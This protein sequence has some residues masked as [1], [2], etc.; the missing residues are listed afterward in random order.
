MYIS[1]DGRF[2]QDSG[3]FIFDI[4][5]L[6]HPRLIDSYNRDGYLAGSIFDGSIHYATHGT[7]TVIVDLAQPAG[8][9]VL[10][11]STNLFTGRTEKAGNLFFVAKTGELAIV[12]AVGGTNLQQVG[13][14]K[15]SSFLYPNDLAVQGNL[16]FLSDSEELFIINV[17]DPAAPK[18]L[19]KHDLP[20]TVINGGIHRSAGIIGVYSDH[21]YLHAAVVGPRELIVWDVSDPLQPKEVQRL[22]WLSLTPGP[23]RFVDDRLYLLTDGWSKSDYKSTVMVT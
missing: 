7:N 21:L 18:L 19:A 9:N 16:V 13:V 22:E 12:D 5:D 1:A 4:S 14:F 6:T 17:S 8:S 2:R 15:D 23:A 10:A 20:T 3:A 11:T